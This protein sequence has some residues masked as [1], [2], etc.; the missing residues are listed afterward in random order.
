MNT[1]LPLRCEFLEYVEE[2][3]KRLYPYSISGFNLIVDPEVLRERLDQLEPHY[4]RVKDENP[5]CIIYLEAAHYLCPEIQKMVFD[6][7]GPCLDILGMNEEE[8]VDFTARLGVDTDPNSLPSVLQGLEAVVSQHSVKGIVLHTK[9]YALYYGQ[10]LPGVSGKGPHHWQPH[11]G[12]QSPH[13]GVRHSR[14]LPGNL[15]TWEPSPK[16]LSLPRSWGPAN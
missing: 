11:G 7:L 5:E 15:S 3:A 10:E 13:R 1:R 14:G 16:G 9:D 8:L 4:R 2:N 6:R 12:N